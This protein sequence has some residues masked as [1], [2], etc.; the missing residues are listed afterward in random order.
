MDWRNRLPRPARSQ[1]PDNMFEI[2]K[3]TPEEY[4]REMRA[5][6]FGE[7]YIDRELAD[8]ERAREQHLVPRLARPAPHAPPPDPA[9]STSCCEG[10]RSDNAAARIRRTSGLP[11]SGS[12]CR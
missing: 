3:M 1:L 9:S 5:H 6:G 8:L 10:K 7:E 12:V 4:R 2:L 11:Q